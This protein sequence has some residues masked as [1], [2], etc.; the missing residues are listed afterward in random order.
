MNKTP[1]HSTSFDRPTTPQHPPHHLFTDRQTRGIGWGGVM[2]LVGELPASHHLASS[3]VMGGGVGWV[4]RWSST[5]TH[6]RLF[7]TQTFLFT[8]VTPYRQGSVQQ[9]PTTITSTSFF[10]SLSCSVLARPWATV[11]SSHTPA[12]WTQCSNSSIISRVNHYCM[13]DYTLD[14]LLRK[15]F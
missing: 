15:E 8:S 14:I 9:L 5:G 11:P 13:E 2:E 10:P 12:G 4:H 1:L 7:T 6:S 3:P